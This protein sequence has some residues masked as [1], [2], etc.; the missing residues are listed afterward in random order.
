MQ[1]AALVL[2]LV[3]AATPA[4]GAPPAPPPAPVPTPTPRPRPVGPVVALD[5][6]AGPRHARHDHDRARHGEGADQRRQLP[7]VRARRPLRRDDVPPRDAGLHDPGRRLHAGD[8]GEANPLADPERGDRTGCATRAARWRWRGSTTRTARRASSSSTCATTTGSTSGSAGA[9]YAV[10]GAGRRGH[11]R[12]RADRE[13][14]ATSRGPHENVPQASD[15]HPARA[16]DTA[17]SRAPSRRRAGR[18]R[19]RRARPPRHAEPCYR[20]RRTP[21]PAPRPWPGR[22]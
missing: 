15:H 5:V 12:R 9:G 3:Q 6:D 4:A 21:S 16:G 22:A 2:T 8:G 10:F 13:V 19:S 1:L 20:A 7:A 14:V 17:A 11:G 18:S